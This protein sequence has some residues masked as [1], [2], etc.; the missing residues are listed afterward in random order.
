VSRARELS[1]P[2][3]QRQNIKATTMARD[4]YRYFRVEAREL[5]DQLGQGALE[6]DKGTA[7]PE[8]IALMLRLA[9]TLK[10]AARVVKQREIADHAHAIED[11]LAPFREKGTAVSRD[12][13]EPTLK[14]LDEIARRL[15]ALA[16]QPQGESAA[17]DFGST[18]VGIPSIQHGSLETVT[19]NLDEMDLLLESISEASV[20]VSA[21]RRELAPLQRSR[22]LTQLLEEQ[23]L[24]PRTDRFSGTGG[25]LL[26]MA[27]ELR[28]L[29]E[30][31]QR[32][33]NDGLEQMDRELVQA[34]EAAERL[35]LLPARLMFVS[36]ERTARDAA[37]A[38]SKRID[39]VT[40]GGDVRLDA[41]V[42]GVVQSALVQ[43]VRNAVAHGIETA[44]EREAYAKPTVGHVWV[45]VRRRGHQAVFVCRDDGRG[46]DLEDVRRVAERKGLLPADA[47]KLGTDELLRL[48]L[49]GGISTSAAV[50]QI[51]GRGIGLDI[52]REA[53]ARL[54]GEVTIQTNRGLGTTLEIVVPVSLAAVDALIVEAGGRTVAIPLDAVK[55]TLRVEI[56]D[57]A[58]SAQGASIM[59]EG[60]VIPFAPLERALRRVSHTSHGAR[61]WSA[62]VI[63]GANTLAATGVERLRGTQNLVVRPL[64]GSTPSD[65]IVAGASLDAEGHPQLLLDPEGLVEHICRA[66][67]A[68]DAMPAS[69]A[70]ILV[71]DD[72]LTTRM[73]EQSILESAGYEVDLATSGEDA[74][75]RARKRRYSLFLV[76]V[77]MPGMDGFTFIEHARRD[78]SLRDIPAVMV[79]SRGSPEDR[80]RGLHVGAQA[81]IV[82]GEFDQTELLEQ[83]RLL[84]G[85]H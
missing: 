69:R 39:F 68:P 67:S 62:V 78:P 80:Q 15:A 9:H 50:T 63:E 11:A 46:I 60:K 20:E 47:A 35:R 44:A 31:V 8:L 55:R 2:P 66:G 30:S 71:I 84:M 37:Q 32:S 17:D 33:F 79:T 52:V 70:P 58:H 57:L 59:F 64:P 36:L 34:R 13:I 25:K 54:R 73:L 1:N 41:Q 26:S 23:A 29:V 48:L 19:T 22:R 56:G 4:P 18:V 27:A 6:L 10:G 24:A 82:K 53:A 40:S 38:F 51:A 49:G 28:S 61:S 65:P 77:E 72:S 3:D 43:T 5:L 14:A 42:F 83:I 12:G 76:D 75:E 45:E 16:P 21:M 7:A 81:Y 85:A 74:L